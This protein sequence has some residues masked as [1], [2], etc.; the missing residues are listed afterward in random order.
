[1]AGAI[2]IAV[3]LLIFP[4]LVGIGGFVLAAA[5]GWLLNDD[6]ASRAEGSEL[7]ELNQ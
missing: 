5:L 4:L 6:A 3:I 7:A 1:V 2:T